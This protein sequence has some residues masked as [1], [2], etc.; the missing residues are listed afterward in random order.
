MECNLGPLEKCIITNK[1]TS[2]HLVDSNNYIQA[3]LDFHGF[4][5]GDFWFTAV[6]NSI[7]F[8]S[9][10][11]LGLLS[12]LNLCRFCS[13]NFHLC[14]HI[15]SLIRGMPVVLVW[16]QCWSV[17][18]GQQLLSRAETQTLKQ[19]KSWVSNPKFQTHKKA[20]IKIPNHRT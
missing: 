4:D 16:I 11:Y 18:T 8:S 19:E 17:F 10:L 7:L 14:H 9:P 20:L 15:N 3:I 6:Y 2:V 1:V 12:N 5:F 13:R